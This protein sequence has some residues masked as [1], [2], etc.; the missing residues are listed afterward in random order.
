MLKFI[1]SVFL[2]V[3]SI[4]GVLSQVSIRLI[5]CDDSLSVSYAH[6]QN[7]SRDQISISNE[8]GDFSFNYANPEDK[9][10]ISHIAFHDTV[11]YVSELLNI[12]KLCLTRKIEILDEAVVSVNENDD[13]LINAV[14]KTQEKLVIPIRLSVYFKEFI[15]NNDSYI[16]FSDA[17]LTYYLYKGKKGKLDV[18]L[19]V[20]QSRAYRIPSNTEDEIDFEIISP[21]DDKKLIGYFYP[22]EIG[23]FLEEETR[24]RYEYE[25]VDYSDNF[26]I[27]CSP[28]NDKPGVFKGKVVVRKSDST[29]S[30]ISFLIPEERIHLTKESNAMVA[31]V[32]IISNEGYV[33]YSYRSNGDLYLSHARLSYTVQIR[34]KKIDEKLTFINDINVYDIPTD[35]ER[36]SKS[37]VYKKKSI[38]KR[39]IDYDSDYWS[40]KSLIQLTELEKDIIQKISENNE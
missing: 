9:I 32:R 22:S 11:V 28:K 15:K 16:R 35:Q 1:F 29:I 39:G 30:A 38:Y 4:D 10:K 31:K 3:L 7:I 19:G 26:I 25:L 13:F 37:D 17:D 40:N 20:S 24:S 18:D 33:K 36:I 27:I 23:R 21:I 5:S 2:I 14:K 8:E 6:I 12:E 34:N